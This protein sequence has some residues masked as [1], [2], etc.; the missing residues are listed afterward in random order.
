M[1]FEKSK[2]SI[3]LVA[4]L[5]LFSVFLAYLVLSFRHVETPA[6]IFECK[7]QKAPFRANISDCMSV[8]VYPSDKA[9]SELVLSPSV[10][11]IYILIEPNGSAGLALS[12]Y[13]IYKTLKAINIPVSVAYTEY[14][15]NQ[16][17]I[18]VMRMGEAT[19][20]KPIIWLKPS[21]TT[22]SIELEAAGIT[23]RANSQYGL[24][25]AACRLAIDVIKS[26]YGC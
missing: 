20:I 23:I 5:V 1:K 17:E 19:Y 15:A 10:E 18:P 6:N 14:W 25:S 9:L 4:F 22:T 26:T 16:S 24:D 7:G 3:A 12:S 21:E 13:E 11:S 2:S 8:P